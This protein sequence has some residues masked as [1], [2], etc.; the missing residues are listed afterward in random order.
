VAP[1]LAARLQENCSN[2]ASVIAA[3]S[4]YMC[5]TI[6][7]SNAGIPSSI[8]TA[9]VTSGSASRRLIWSGV[10]FSILWVNP[11]TPSLAVPT[12]PAYAEP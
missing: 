9:E 4:P 12:Y 7:S 8:G 11:T 2:S 10:I 1:P 5:R 6:A 3:A